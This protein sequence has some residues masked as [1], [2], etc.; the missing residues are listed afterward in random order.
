VL[1][2]VLVEVHC[3]KCFGSAFVFFADRD[4]AQNLNADPDPECRSNVDQGIINEYFD[5]FF[6]YREKL[7]AFI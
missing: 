6:K 4:P 3:E 7:Y 5:I 1:N 2:D